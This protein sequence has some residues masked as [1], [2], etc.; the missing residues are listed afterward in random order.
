MTALPPPP[1]AAS[2]ELVFTVTG[3]AAVA[4]LAIAAIAALAL[5]CWVLASTPRTIRLTHI[6][7]ALRG[8]DT[9]LP[10]A[11]T[12]IRARPDKTLTK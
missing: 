4:T 7:N 11:R 12:G 1:A 3:W 5:L 9:R 8:R 6:I 10:L 2:G